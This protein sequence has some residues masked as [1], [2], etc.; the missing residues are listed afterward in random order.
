[1]FSYSFQMCRL[2]L[3]VVCLWAV[4][5]AGGSARAEPIVLQ[6]VAGRTVVLPA[7]A[8]RVVLAQAPINEGDSGGPVLNDQAELVA[9]TQSHDPK[10]RLVTYSIAASEIKAFVQV[11]GKARDAVAAKR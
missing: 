2:I 11:A 7:P 6:D 8:K 10:G 4:A 1:M 3:V 5:F 9:I